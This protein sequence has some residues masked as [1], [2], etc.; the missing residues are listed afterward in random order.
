MQLII[1]LLFSAAK[2]LLIVLIS[3]SLI[4]IVTSVMLISGVT[5]VSIGN[6]ELQLFK[7]FIVS[8]TLYKVYFTQKMFML[9]CLTQHELKIIAISWLS[10]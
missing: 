9:S 4:S 1:N 10:I 5:Q 7:Q 2:V 8:P 3:T 6:T